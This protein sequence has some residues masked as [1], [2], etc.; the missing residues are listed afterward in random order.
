MI[1]PTFSEFKRLARRHNLIPLVRETLVD[2]VTPVSVYERLSAGEPYSFLLESVEG[3]ERFGRY[4]F[5]GQRPQATFICKGNEVTYRVGART[6][7][8]KTSN[9]AQDLK[10]IFAD[11]STPNLPG[12][13][14]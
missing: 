9:P 13:P 5:V 11:I 2:R 14:R 4:S 7:S 1:R 12:L 6:K 10:K 3:G 8:W